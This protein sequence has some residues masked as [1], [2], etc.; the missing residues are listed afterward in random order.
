MLEDPLRSFPPAILPPL[1]HPTERA[2][3]AA[4]QP[5]LVWD[6]DR[7]QQHLTS[8]QGVEAC[9]VYILLTPEGLGAWQLDHGYFLSGTVPVHC[10]DS[11]NSLTATGV[12]YL[13][14]LLETLLLGPPIRRQKRYSTVTIIR[15]YGGGRGYCKWACFYWSSSPFRVLVI[16][17]GVIILP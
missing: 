1:R 13:S 8:H 9:S 14:S 6:L 4:G 15:N 12:P 2:K 5:F 17:L 16:I 11:Y 10:R 7:T 3:M